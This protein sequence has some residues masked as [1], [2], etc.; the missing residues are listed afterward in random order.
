VARLEMIDPRKF[1]VAVAATAG[2]KADV[3][4]TEEEAV[5]WLRQ[6]G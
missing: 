3:F 6:L 5:A 4:V 2:L 1:G